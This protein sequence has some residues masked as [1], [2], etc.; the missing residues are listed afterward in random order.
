[1]NLDKFQSSKS[2]SVRLGGYL[3]SDSVSTVPVD[4][5]TYAKAAKNAVSRTIIGNVPVVRCKIPLLTTD[6][7]FF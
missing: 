1:M 2:E 4:L 6:L 7:P 3:F 5:D